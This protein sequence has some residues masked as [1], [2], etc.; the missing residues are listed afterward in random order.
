MTTP[1]ENPS[2][3]TRADGAGLD[4]D[5]V[6]TR[7][8]QCG[9]VATSTGVSYAITADGGLDP[10]HPLEITC[11]AVGHRYSAAFIDLLA[12]D[13]TATCVRC[14][15]VFAVPAVADQV[16]CPS[17]RLYQDGPFLH[18]DDSRRAELDRTRQAHLAQIRAALR[19][20]RPPPGVS[21][22]DE[23]PVPTRCIR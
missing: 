4:I 23:Q 2:Y 10:A 21:G 16:V 14:D 9:I 3:Q 6:Y 7:C 19:A 11:N 20:S 8:P 13:A 1:A 22:D 15:T 5:T 18:A 12:H 17:C